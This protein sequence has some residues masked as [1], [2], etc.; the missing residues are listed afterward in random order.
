[1]STTFSTIAFPNIVIQT[2]GAPSN[3]VGINGQFAW[4]AAASTL[5]GPKS[6]GVW[7]AGVVLLGA[8]GPAGPTGPQGP[9]GGLT[10]RTSSS[11]TTSSVA[12]GGTWTGTVS[13]AK[14]FALIGIE[15]DYP[16][17][18]RV[19][20]TAAART[21]DASRLINED[22]QGVISAEIATSTIGPELQVPY[23]SG[24]ICAN[25]DATPSTLQYLSL[26]NLDSVSR[27]FVVNL[28]FIPLEA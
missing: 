24:V 3:S 11:V 15:L 4:D 2:S 22:P 9:P 18:L 12:A 23:R 10:A 20:P 26:K 21:A 27:V 19:Y 7:P 13:L 1:M 16:G 14:T 25:L 17:W 5:Y 8:Q 28:Y 6:N